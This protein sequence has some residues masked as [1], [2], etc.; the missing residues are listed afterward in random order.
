MK[1]GLL[2]LTLLAACEVASAAPYEHAIRT[3]YQE[4]GTEIEW[5]VSD[6]QFLKTPE[7]KFD[8]KSSPPFGMS[9]AYQR[10]HAW[11]KKTFPKMSSFR[12]REYSVSTAGSSR[13]PNRWYYTFEFFG[14]LDGSVVTNS[15]FSVM[16]LMDG[17]IIEPK[18]K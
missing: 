8:G 13:V 10:A 15:R 16:V 2:T 12:L 18:A 7:W 3:A 4:D 1:R 6:A 9:D 11:L 5:H 17:T 14:D